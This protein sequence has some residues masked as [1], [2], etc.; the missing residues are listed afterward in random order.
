MGRLLLCAVNNDGRN[1]GV[2]GFLG[3]LEMAVG[4]ELLARYGAT[5][6]YG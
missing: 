5:S 2:F 6:T 4:Y 3:R 1:G